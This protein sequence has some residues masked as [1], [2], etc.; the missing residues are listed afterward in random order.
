MTFQ[1]FI[2]RFLVDIFD[3]F[4]LISLIS[5]MMDDVITS[6]KKIFIGF[7]L[8]VHWIFI[9]FSDCVSPPPPQRTGGG[10]QT[11]HCTAPDFHF[12]LQKHF[13]IS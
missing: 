6:Y 3:I 12:L 10:S 11:V 1:C 7:S 5:D 13:N 2:R 8:D 4:D 9:G